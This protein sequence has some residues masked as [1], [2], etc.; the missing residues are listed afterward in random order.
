MP[1]FRKPIAQPQQLSDKQMSLCRRFISTVRQ[2]DRSVPE[3]DGHVA[4]HTLR[5]DATLAWDEIMLG[6]YERFERA[7]RTYLSFA[8]EA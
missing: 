6:K 7:Y 4:M 5:G 2:S 8:E 3:V 1:Q